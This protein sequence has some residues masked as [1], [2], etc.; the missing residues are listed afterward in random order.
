MNKLFNFSIAMVLMWTMGDTFKT[1]YFIQREAPVQFGV[2]G[3]LQVIIDLSILLQVYL[4]QTKPT[5]IR[6]VT[7]TD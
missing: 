5:V 1:C 2:C 7:R 6:N 3:V 4:Y